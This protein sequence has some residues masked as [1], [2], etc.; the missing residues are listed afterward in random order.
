MFYD[1]A[2]FILMLFGTLIGATGY[3]LD[4]I[5]RADFEEWLWLGII[6]ILTVSG[7]TTGRLIQH[8]SKRSYTDYLTGI[9]NRRYFYVRLNEELSRLNRK[10]RPLCIAMV[11]IDGFKTVNDIYGHAVG[12]CLL[13]EIATI[14][15]KYT[16]TTDVVSRF[17][18]DEFAIIFSETSLENTLEVMER[19]RRKVETS[20]TPY[21]LTIS[22][23]VVPFEPDFDTKTFMIKADRVLYKAKNRKNSI[24]TAVSGENY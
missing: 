12:D 15:K 4:Y 19:I 24:I 18:G 10:K 21:A 3:Y 5:C 9:W 14:L 11:D 20:F 8:L 1:Y 2:P 16:R 23:G 13:V 22:A 6:V 7:F 17:G